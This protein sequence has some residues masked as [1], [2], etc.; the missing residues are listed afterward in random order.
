[1]ANETSF[2]FN[3]PRGIAMLV[4][5]LALFGVQ[6]VL[7]KMLSG[8]IAVMEVVFFRS[9]VALII[10]WWVVRRE[11][12]LHMLRTRNIKLITLRGLIGLSCYTSYYMALAMLPLADVIVIAFS[13]P[14]FVAALAVPILGERLDLLR[15]IAVLVGFVGVIIAMD[16]TGVTD[17]AVLLAVYAAISYAAQSIIT[18]KLGSTESG[19][20]LAFWHLLIFWLGS[21]LAGLTL[22]SGWLLTPDSHPS[23]AFLLRAWTV[24]TMEQAQWL[25]IIGLIAGCGFYLLSQAYRIG[26]ASSVA[27]FEFSAIIWGVLWGFLVWQQLPDA[28]MWTGMS[29]IVASGLFLLWWESR[30]IRNTVNVT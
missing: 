4:I 7:V 2:E 3:N 21:C 16:P 19:G 1:M 24:P 27:P 11:G 28:Q 17:P 15:S 5:G 20:S 26:Q 6:D 22:G 9:P 8:E 13:A 14:L 29:L 23:I 10:A 25:L 12:G 30:L 18:R